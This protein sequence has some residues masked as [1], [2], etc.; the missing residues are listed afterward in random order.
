VAPALEILDTRIFRTDPVTNVHRTVFDTIAD[1]AANGGIVLGT[2]RFDPTALDLGW[3]GAIVSRNGVV[4]ETGLGAGVLGDPLASMAWLANRLAEHGDHIRA[5][6]VVLSGAFIRA[7][8]APSGAEFA[9]DFGAL[10]VVTCS[11]E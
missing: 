9:A 5:G 6:E 8:E 10:G 7:I 4:E 1:N 11:F 3:I 2:K